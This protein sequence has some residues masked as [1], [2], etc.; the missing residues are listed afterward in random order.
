MRKKHSAQFKA[1]VALDAI[2]ETKTMGELS[3]QYEVHR[4]QLQSWKKQAIEHL[5]GIFASKKTASIEKEKQKLIDELYKK[6][7]K[8]EVENE[9]LK[10]KSEAFN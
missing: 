2:R 9:W 8:L 6:I 4:V 7:G 10:K 5:P 3:S 1:K